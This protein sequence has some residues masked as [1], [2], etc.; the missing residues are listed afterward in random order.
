MLSLAKKQTFHTYERLHD[1]LILEYANAEKE[2]GNFVDKVLVVDTAKTEINV[3][4]LILAYFLEF[5]SFFDFQNG[6][7][8][9][10]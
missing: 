7:K 3:H 8:K 10:F 2:K 9:I 1:P 4:S 5:F 6:S